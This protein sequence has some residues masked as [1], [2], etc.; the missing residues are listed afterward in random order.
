MLDASKEHLKGG[1]RCLG[2]NHKPFLWP[3]WIDNPLEIE[4]RITFSRSYNTRTSQIEGFLQIWERRLNPA[5]TALS[6]Q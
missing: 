3:S 6:V 4:H 1:I 2:E 5:T